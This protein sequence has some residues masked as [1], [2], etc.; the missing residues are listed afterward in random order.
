MGYVATLCQLCGVAFS[1]ARIR[2]AHE[3]YESAWT[4]HG[5]GFVDAMEICEGDSGCQ[6]FERENENELEHVAGPGCYALRGYSGY[7]VSVED[8]AGCR[9]PQCLLRKDENWEQEDDDQEFEKTSNYYLTG[10]SDMPP[11]EGWATELKP[12]RHG[13]EEVWV[14]NVSVMG[15]EDDQSMP[16]HPA[17]FE[18]FKKVSINR[19][20]L[21]DVHGLWSWRDLEAVCYDDFRQFPRSQAVKAGNQQWW[22]HEPGNEYLAVNPVTIPG[23]PALL[24]SAIS[25]HSDVRRRGANNNNITNGVFTFTYK[26]DGDHWKGMHKTPPPGNKS[27]FFSRL[28]N[29][30]RYMI[31]SD[32]PAR[33]IANLRLVTPAYRQLPVS[34][35]RTLILHEMPW[36][37]EVHD[38]PVGKTDWYFLYTKMKFGWQELKGL[39]NRKRVWKDINEIVTRIANYRDA[40]DIS[41]DLSDGSSDDQSLLLEP[42]WYEAS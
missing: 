17:C 13:L 42:S 23:F 12:V 6:Y 22:E 29:E 32:L 8:M 4:Y 11:D 34:V 1:I 14:S 9:S 35:F 15:F 18:I 39:R 30:I 41:D 27:D 24:R 33:D 26:N 7:R 40:G 21:I 38:F 36:L 19:L 5:S 2:A 16:F 31:I 3:P 20:G 10:L 28:P 25:E 37:W